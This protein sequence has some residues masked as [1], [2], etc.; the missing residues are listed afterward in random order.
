MSTAMASDPNASNRLLENALIRICKLTDRQVQEIISTQRENNESFIE[1][2][3]HLGYATETDVE[4]ALASCRRIALVEKKAL[5]PSEQL[6]LLHDP[7]NEHSEKVRALRTELLLRPDIAGRANAIAVL[8]PGAGEGRSLL[9]AELAISFA[10]LGQ[11]T[12][13][14]DADFR[15]PRQQVLFG[16]DSTKGLSQ[17]IASSG[18]THMQAV[19]GLPHL[20]VL[21]TGEIPPS[22]LEYLS[23]GRFGLLLD[24]LSHRY[25]HIVVDTPPAGATSD[26]LAIAT[27]VGRVLILGRANHTPYKATREM[28]RRLAASRSQVL[29]AVLNRY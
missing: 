17:A 22:P 8:S 25:D 6:R 7:Y 1:A 9:A 21:T 23:D 4:R 11:S 19:E 13:L 5:S 15:H 2:A 28:M 29:G 3:K 18:S 27:L 24:D 16:S 26:A 20:S 14:I 10:Q 12:L